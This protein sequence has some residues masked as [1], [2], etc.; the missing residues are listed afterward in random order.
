LE[1]KLVGFLTAMFVVGFLIGIIGE[2][3][4]VSSQITD[5]QRQVS[6]LQTQILSLQGQ[7]ETLQSQI[8]TRILGVYFSPDG[9]CE[10]QIR[11]WIRRANSTI[12]ILIYSF[13]LDSI[14]D[15]LIE[16]YQRGVEVRVVFEKQQITKYS[17]YLKLKAAGVPV[18]NDTNP[19]LMHNKV[20]I[21]DGIIV[22][23]GSF[24][25]SAAGE[26]ENNEN[27]IVI[28]SLEVAEIYE[29]EFERIW[30]ASV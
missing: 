7:I 6:T 12:H 13:T 10:D 16:A 28:S 9:G 1:K 22:L 19:N 23:T 2:Y 30:I 27:L 18:R 25:Y 20:M 14:G 24:N 3:G 17:E 26:E 4:A 29:E 8:S 21:I 11:Y 15:A 5:L